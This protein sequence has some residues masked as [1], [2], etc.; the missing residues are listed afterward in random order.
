MPL[1]LIGFA[2]ALSAPEA[3]FS[4]RNAGFDVRVFCRRGARPLLARCLPVGAA[5]EITAP[6]TDAAATQSELAAAVAGL[7]ETQGQEPEQAPQVLVLGLDDP[8]LWLVDTLF[9][10]GGISGARAVNPVG[11]PVAVA[12]DKIAQIKAARAAGL[13]VPETTVAATHAEIR[14]AAIPEACIVKPAGPIRLKD[15]QLGKGGTHFFSSAE[16]RTT[17]PDTLDIAFPSLVQPLIRGWGEGIFGFAGSRGICA[18]S[19]H[20]RIRMMNP[21]GSGASACSP[22]TPEPELCAKVAKMIA[23]IGWRGPF[24]IEFLRA[25]D[26]TLYFMELNGRLWGSLALARRGGFEYPA[27]A[28]CQALDSAFEPSSATPPGPTPPPVM[29]HLGREI[30]HVLHVLRGPK[31][32]FH[33]QGWPPFWPTLGAVLRF[34]PSRSFY[35]WDP[36]HPRYFLYDAW[37]T[38]LDQFMGR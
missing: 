15:G 1:V 21:H 28:V 12:L 18:W 31:S 34:G 8:G 14:T 33:R 25:N 23:A 5:I 36:A 35:N 7:A 20:R 30:L 32:A 9:A 16:A 37:S 3:V 19:A 2:E 38:V 29:R 22:R 24:M 11:A 4:L 27:W 13:A 6:E 10:A 17:L 26:G